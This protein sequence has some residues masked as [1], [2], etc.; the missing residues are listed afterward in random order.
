M[1]NPGRGCQPEREKTKNPMSVL[2]AQGIQFFHY[3]PRSNTL[4]NYSMHAMG[5]NRVIAW[6]ALLIDFRGASEKFQVTKGAHVWSWHK[7]CKAKDLALLTTAR[8]NT[9]VTL[10]NRDLGLT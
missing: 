2:H 4:L 8:T 1:E 9:P 6:N 10:P 3:K 7:T 5:R